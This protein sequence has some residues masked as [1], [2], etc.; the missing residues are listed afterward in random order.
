[1]RLAGLDSAINAQARFQ[2]GPRADPDELE[3]TTQINSGGTSASPKLKT[4]NV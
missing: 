3:R 2:T 1:M 4:P